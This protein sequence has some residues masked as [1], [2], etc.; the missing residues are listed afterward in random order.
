MSS[1]GFGAET[2]AV[3]AIY[4]GKLPYFQITDGNRKSATAL[5][6]SAAGSDAR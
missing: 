5:G 6:I 2:A 3:S 4:F 1:V